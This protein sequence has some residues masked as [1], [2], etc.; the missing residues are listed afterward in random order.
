[1]RLFANLGEALYARPTSTG[2]SPPGAAMRSPAVV[3][4]L[5]GSCL[6]VLMQFETSSTAPTVWWRYLR[7]AVRWMVAAI[8]PHSP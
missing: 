2:S 4:N 8:A 1:M 6:V 3:A 5:T 7:P